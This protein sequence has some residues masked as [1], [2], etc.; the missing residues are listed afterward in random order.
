MDINKF[1]RYTA[2]ASFIVGTFFLLAFIVTGDNSFEY[3]GLLYVVIAA[4]F[5]SLLLFV[6]IIK[7]IISK[8]RTGA[9][10]TVFLMLL[11]IPVVIIYMSIVDWAESR[12]PIEFVNHT[13]NTIEKFEIY[14]DNELVESEDNFE[15]GEGCKHTFA[16]TDNNIGFMYFV[17][18]VEYSIPN[19]LQC[20]TQDTKWPDYP[21]IYKVGIDKYICTFDACD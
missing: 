6:I 12:M 1:G 21:I 13:G 7:A 4:V 17:N 19:I 20:E 10:F 9:S 14:R 3:M 5:N 16:K 15:N 18:G 11:N 2:L 8:E